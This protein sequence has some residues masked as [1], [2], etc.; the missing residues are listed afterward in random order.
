MATT[1][2]LGFCIMFYIYDTL[3]LYK[4]LEIQKEGEK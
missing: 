2:L 3:K 1:I 4:R